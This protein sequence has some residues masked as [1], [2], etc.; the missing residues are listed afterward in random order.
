MSK[1]DYYANILQSL[2][3]WEPYLLENS[4]LPGR[5]ANIELARAFAAAG[6]EERIERFLTNIPELAPTNSPREF[7]AFCGVL[8]LGQ[9]VAQGQVERLAALRQAAVDPR[10]RVREAVA[11]A[12]QRYGQTA[13]AALLM[14]M[15]TW[16]QG[17]ALERRAAAAAL[18][19]PG[20]LGEDWIVE[21]TLAIVDE[22]TGS[23]KGEADGK[24]EQFRILRQAL[25][26]C[27]S[28]VVAANPERGKAR[29]EQWLA[30]DDEDIRWIMKQNLTK[31]RLQKMDEAWVAA[32]EARLSA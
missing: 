21:E 27:W 23:L 28:V 7:L 14:E 2:D 15:R 17:G 11:M 13:P 6:D 10:W 26:Y 4:G 22:I 19:E 30:D 1:V 16:A 25:G 31:K 20:F 3:D 8:G 32:W 9:L 18:C 12:L 29:M 24:S 5:R